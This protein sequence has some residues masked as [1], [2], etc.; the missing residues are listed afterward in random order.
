MEEERPGIEIIA[1]DIQFVISQAFSILACIEKSGMDAELNDKLFRDWSPQDVDNFLSYMRSNHSD[2]M[3]AALSDQL[4]A[5]AV[6][7]GIEPATDALCEGLRERILLRVEE[8]RGRIHT[9]H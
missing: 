6:I 3:V 5:E 8:E 9:Q 4:P 7:K 2:H 1:N